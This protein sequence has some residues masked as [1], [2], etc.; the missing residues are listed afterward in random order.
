M[1]LKKQFR[2]F[3]NKNKDLIA[4]NNFDQLYLNAMLDSNE[5]ASWVGEL[6]KLF[7]D[8]RI[9]PLQHLSLIPPN[10]LYHS[11]ISEIAIPE[12][13]RL[14][15]IMSNAFS[16]TLIQHL[17]IPKTIK[18]L[19]EQALALMPSLRSCHFSEGSCSQG[20]L[21]DFCFKGCDKLA[22]LY[23]P[24]S[25][26]RIG[27]NCFAGCD[28]LMRLN[29]AG[30]SSQLKQI[31]FDKDTFIGSSVV[32]IICLGDYSTISVEEILH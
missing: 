21:S 16:Y 20:G 3:I 11:L 25:I 32:E 30:D 10:Y 9:D 29:Y 23:L 7:I 2:N 26:K 6:T 28:K 4:T 1:E 22:Y 17:E 12:K 24:L 31:D 8:A 19:E 18:S 13:E 14:T 15:T 27:R 5:S